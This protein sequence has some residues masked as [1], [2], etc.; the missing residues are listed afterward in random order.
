MTSPTTLVF[1]GGE[2]APR[3]GTRL[4]VL[5]QRQQVIGDGT[6]QDDGTVVL[7][8]PHEHRW[9]SAPDLGSALEMQLCATTGCGGRRAVTQRVEQL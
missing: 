2:P 5:D 4:P 3:P 6:V 9:I 7:T 8:F 1:T